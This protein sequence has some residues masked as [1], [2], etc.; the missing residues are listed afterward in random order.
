MKRASILL[1]LLV[2]FASVS[3]TLVRAGTASIFSVDFSSDTSLVDTYSSSS[4]YTDKDL[5]HWYLD[6]ICQSV[7]GG[8]GYDST[9]KAV[10]L[11]LDSS[12]NTGHYRAR[13]A[14]LKENITI[15]NNF[16]VRMTI[17]ATTNKGAAVGAIIFA[18]NGLVY[19]VMHYGGANWAI[20]TDYGSETMGK[21]AWVDNDY[22]FNDL[23]WTAVQAGFTTVTFSP[24]DDLKK[25]GVQL[26]PGDIDHINVFFGGMIYND[27]VQYVY[28][29]SI[30][31]LA[32][33]GS[34]TFSIKDALSGQ[35]LTGVTVKEGS[36][37][38]GTLDDGQSL[39]LTKGQHTLTFEKPGYW[40]VTKTIDV[41]GDMSVSV[42]LYPSSAAFKLENFPSNISIPEHT[43]YTLTF[44]LTPIDTS[45]TYNTYLS[46][47]G[48]SNVLEVRK[49]GSVIS[50][51]GGKYYL[52]DISSPVQISIKFKATS[53]GTYA[54]SL[55]LES[56]D[57]FGTKMYTTTKQVSYKVDPL[58][59]TVE[60]PSEWQV[61]DNQLRVSEAS[62]QSYAMV[63][64]L[65]DSS[66][67]QV[68][69]DS[70]AF[71]PYDVHTFTVNVPEE[72]TYTLEFQWNGQTASYTINVG[73]GISLLTKSV[74][75]KKG[76]VGTVQVQ[77]KNPSDSTK[78]YTIRLEGGFLD[79]PVNQTVAIA[80]SSTKT[81]SISFAVPD[82]LTYDAYDLTMKVLEGD[83]E[84]YS[85]TVHVI[86]TGSEA[87]LPI[88]LGG[89]SGLP[90][91]AI[92]AAAALGLGAVLVMRRR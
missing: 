39:E 12:G 61:G 49:D 13:V 91:L 92:G 34:V 14:I 70:Y 51:E 79:V 73:T 50:P 40:S 66:G 41:Q 76:G 87:G 30:E 42:E 37:I 82:K 74:S 19:S 88:G 81:V 67:S 38:L 90:L 75:V 10:Y 31:V 58:P 28:L 6:S 48:L 20:G 33:S 89:G 9:K 24:L 56:H 46:L 36:T 15:G 16:T 32:P 62:G 18:K 77:L 85:G 78:Y 45:A 83:A 44:T 57:A 69:S 29:K 63:V 84:R 8:I 54:F 5:P 72:G 35:G 86:I 59:F 71:N 23:N 55:T 4:W 1:A 25:K 60:M 11:K 65:T 2:L 26:S 17:Y 7:K 3:M 80:P 52:G 27:V 64:V 22:R 43:L 47:A 68:W 21:L 53:V